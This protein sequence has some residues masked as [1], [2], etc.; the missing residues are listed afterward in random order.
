MPQEGTDAIL[1]AMEMI[2]EATCHA[3]ASEEAGLNAEKLLRQTLKEHGIRSSERPSNQQ[4]YFYEGAEE[5]QQEHLAAAR[6]SIKERV[7]AL[8]IAQIR[9]KLSW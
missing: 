9:E 8:D 1:T 3:G 2:E 7:D 5:L 6:A 4:V